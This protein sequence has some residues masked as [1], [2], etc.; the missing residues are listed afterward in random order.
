MKNKDI[1][2]E[3]FLSLAGLLAMA[4]VLV[5][6]R[7]QALLPFLLTSAFVAILHLAFSLKHYR[8]L[9]DLAQKLDHALYADQV[10]RLSDAEEGE[11]P[12]LESQIRKL[13]VKL[14]EQ[15]DQLQEDKLVLKE[16]I[17]DIFHQLRTPLTVLFIQMELLKDPDLSEDKRRDLVRK[18][19]KECRRMEWLVESLLKLS[20]IDAGTVRF[21]K[22]TVPLRSLLEEAVRSF[23]IPLDVQGV[24]LDLEVEEASFEGDYRWTLEALEN[25]IKNALEHTPAGGDLQIRGMEN[26]LYTEITIQDDGPGF[27]SE[28]LPYLFDRFYKG[29]GASENSIGIG[30]ALSRAIITA[31]NGTIRA[32]NQDGALFRIRFYKSV[33]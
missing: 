8:D 31:Q 26:T 6:T 29:K 17:E 33:V 25:L 23:E 30:L 13:L 3:A 9:A 7:S 32:E 14:H 18:M 2:R 19:S 10:P 11:V 20:K 21:E 28:D 4:L 5:A 1:C 15:K 12:I 24:S 22:T 27:D 16:A